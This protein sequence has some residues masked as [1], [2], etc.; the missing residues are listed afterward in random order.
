M[1][2]PLGV[3]RVLFNAGGKMSVTVKDS[4]L[5]E[6]RPQRVEVV[7]IDF[8][9]L[10]RLIQIHQR[11]DVME[12]WGVGL[13]PDKAIAIV[14]PATVEAVLRKI[15]GAEQVLYFVAQHIKEQDVMSG[16]DRFELIRGIPEQLHQMIGN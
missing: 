3:F 5:F 12:E 8:V 6:N 11:R 2:N 7:C 10:S 4:G 14:C 9:A 13:L 15:S 16:D 1:Q